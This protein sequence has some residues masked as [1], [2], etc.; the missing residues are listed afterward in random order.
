MSSLTTWQRLEPLPRSDDLRPGLRAE[1]ADPLWLVARQRQ[2]GELRGEDAG[3]PIEARLEVMSG[4]LSRVHRGVPGTDA[5]ASAVDHDDRVLPLEVVVEREPVRGTAAGGALAAQAGLH[6]ARLLRL[7]KATRRIAGYVARYGLTDGDLP[8]DDADV[9]RLRR[10]AVGRVIDGRRLHDDLAAARGGAGEL[11]G[12]P[13]EPSVPDEDRAK[14]LSAANAFLEWWDAVLSEPADGEPSAWSSRRMEHGFAVQADLPGGRVVLRAD[15]YRGGKLDWYSFTA[16]AEPDLG[17]PTSARAAD[18]TI[19]TVLPSP[20]SYGGMPAS[21]FWEIEDGTVRFGGLTTG[22]TDLARLLLA[23]FALSYGNDWFVVPVDLPVGSVCAVD[24]FEVTDTFGERALVE[25]STNRTGSVWRLFELDAPAGPQRVSQLYFLAPAL[26]EI[27]ES[28]PVEEV[29]LLRDEMANVVWGV[30]RRYQ[31]GAGTP[32]DRYEEHQRQLAVAQRVETDFGDAQL[33]YRLA[34]DVP[35]HWFPF[36]PVRAA[37]VAPTAGVVQLERRPLVRILADGSSFA[38]EPRGRILTD[39]AP[40]RI[41]EEEVP[42]SGTDVVRSYQ[43]A[44]WIDGRYV[45]WSG[46]QRK[47]GGGE[48]SS[49]LRFDAVGPAVR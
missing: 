40:L 11:T 17:D 30:E 23:E 19:R 24:R 14:V 33:L 47:T 15:E 26:A 32:V 29:A 49:G 13:A 21:R 46:R 48:G 9:A 44:R 27:A 34:T 41:E 28:P 6:F 2:F 31:G 5:A 8:G 43:L 12:L 35:F 25:R 16:S 37:G 38:P 39:A 36:V 7:N 18:R 3:S 22:R 45:L 42:R 10:R 1:I 20:V 4:R